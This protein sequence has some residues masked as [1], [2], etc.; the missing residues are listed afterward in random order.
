[1]L[2]WRDNCLTGGQ[3]VNGTKD[4][5]A[6]GVAARTTLYQVDRIG[7]NCNDVNRE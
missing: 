5:R 1:M 7:A 4:R 2:R 3:H 6:N